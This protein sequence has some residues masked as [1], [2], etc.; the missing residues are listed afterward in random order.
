MS[1]FIERSNEISVFI[2]ESETTIS[3]YK[4]TKQKPLKH[5]C[6][7]VLLLLY[8]YVYYILIKKYK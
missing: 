1:Q 3:I 4:S 8:E 6:S 2:L 5:Y 7:L